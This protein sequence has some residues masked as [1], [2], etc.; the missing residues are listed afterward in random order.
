MYML[1]INYIMFVGS[2]KS[3]SNTVGSVLYLLPC[4]I[5]KNSLQKLF[6]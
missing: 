4:P 6:F 5:Q 3:P 2:H 1:L